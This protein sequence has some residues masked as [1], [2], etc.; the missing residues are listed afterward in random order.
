MEHD[1][2]KQAKQVMHR[3]QELAQSLLHGYVG[4]E[5]LLVAFMEVECTAGEVLAENGADFI[6]DRP[7]E[8]LDL[9]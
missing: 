2:T 6:I 7:S 8:I 5:H 9:I 1:L 3:A 4:S